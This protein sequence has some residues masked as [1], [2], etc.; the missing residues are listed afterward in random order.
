MTLALHAQ[1]LNFRTCLVILS[2]ASAA[3]NKADIAEALTRLSEETISDLAHILSFGNRANVVAD[4]LFAMDEPTFKQWTAVTARVISDASEIG[5]QPGFINT[6]LP[7]FYYALSAPLTPQQ[8]KTLMWGTAAANERLSNDPRSS[9]RS[10]MER[11]DIVLATSGTGEP[12]GFKGATRVI[13]D[14]ALLQVLLDYQGDPRDVY[15]VIQSQEADAQR[16]SAAL[17]SRAFAPAIS[18]GAL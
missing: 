11:H 15:R 1:S 16:I 2:Y 14:P 17:D 4:Y 12:I 6:T 18:D 8:E 3:R 5:G 10:V 13:I 9:Y 7:I